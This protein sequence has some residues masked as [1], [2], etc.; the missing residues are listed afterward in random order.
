[1]LLSI[2][3]AMGIGITQ[4]SAQSV[5][6]WNVSNNYWSPVYCDGTLV[7]VLEGGVIRVHT[8][9]HFNK[10]G[11]FTWEKAQ[12]KGT[13]ASSSGETFTIKELDKTYFTDHWYVTWTYHLKG[14]EGSHYIGTLT[15]SYFDGSITVGKTRCK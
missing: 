2:C 13:V 1:M 3:L 5:Q 10:D 9:T 4:L 6:N 8:V 7:D 14:D 11:Y 15:Y 12:I